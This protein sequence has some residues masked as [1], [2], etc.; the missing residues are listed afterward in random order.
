MVPTVLV[1]FVAVTSIAVV[2][3]M[4]ILI[5]L[6]L[7][8]KQTSDQL[9]SI[10]LD[11]QRRT[12]PIIETARELLNDGAPKIKEITSNLVD[13]SATVKAQ[14]QQLSTAVNEVLE[15]TRHQVARADEVISRTVHTAGRVQDTVFTPVKRASSIA[16]AISVGIAAFLGKRPQPSNDRAG[17]DE[18]MF[19]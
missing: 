13:T 7:R 15:R 10:A 16:H 19:I 12:A 9:Q 8:V 3:Q 11:V 4:G 5:A 18:G 14:A 6:F 17:T 2:I 1:V